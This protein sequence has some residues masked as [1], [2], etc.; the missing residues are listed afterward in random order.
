MLAVTGGATG[1]T[2]DTANESSSNWTRYL[3]A[4]LTPDKAN[5]RFVVERG[6]VMVKVRHANIAP[7]VE[8]LAFYGLD[9]EWDAVG[10]VG[11]TGT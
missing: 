5:V 1:W 7:N 9:Y 4:S 10:A 8:L 3:N 11:A 2:I 6:I